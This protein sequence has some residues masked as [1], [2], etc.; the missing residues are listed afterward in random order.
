MGR[1]APDTLIYGTKA[2]QEAVS[3]H[4]KLCESDGYELTH[5]DKHDQEEAHKLWS[6]KRERRL[7]RESQ[8]AHARKNGAPKDDEARLSEGEIE[9]HFER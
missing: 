9:V 3:K 6:N 8:H 5:N 4:E 2:A 7:G 1:L